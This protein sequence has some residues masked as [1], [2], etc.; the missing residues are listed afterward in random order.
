MIKAIKFNQKLYY[1]GK[2][3]KFNHIFDDT[4]N[5]LRQISNRT[6]VA[7]QKNIIKKYKHSNLELCNER[8]RR[9]RKYIGQ[10]LDKVIPNEKKCCVCGQL[11][12]KQNFYPSKYSA[13]GLFGHCISCD[14][15][16]QHLRRGKYRK[17]VIRK[18]PELVKENRRKIKRNYKKT[19]KGKIAKTR[20]L[21]R[22]RARLL[23][24]QMEN[25]TPTQ[26]LARFAEFENKCVY[27]GC[28]EKL[29]IDH[30]IP[31]SKK[32]ADCLFNIVPAC[33]KCNSSKYNKHPESWF[34]KQSFYS[35]EKWQRLLDKV[36]S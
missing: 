13:N 23:Q 28:E 29:S 12:P 27:C 3:C 1:L 30:F 5:S 25:Y 36:N 14:K 31:I 6:C 20:E 8:T 9:W 19:L 26:I 32:G 22:R 18:D 15:A 34:K 11:K 7:C 17:P 4:G 16:R 24:V 33:I 2:I 21:Q 10:K 35:I